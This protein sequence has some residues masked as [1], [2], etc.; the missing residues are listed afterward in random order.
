MQLLLKTTMISKDHSS[1]YS[2][3]MKPGFKRKK[4][5]KKRAKVRL[6]KKSVRIR[7]LLLIKV[8]NNR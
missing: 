7:N 2:S 5:S 6:N 8:Q 3:T 4:K 1:S